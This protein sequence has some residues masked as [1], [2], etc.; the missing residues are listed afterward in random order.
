M[1]KHKTARRDFLKA[2]GVVAAPYF[3]PARVLGAEAP[4][5][6]LRVGCIGVGRQGSADMRECLNQGLDPKTAA[7]VVAVCDVDQRRATNAQREVASFYRQQRPG[8]TPSPIDAVSD[9]RELLSRSDIDALLIATP[10]HWHGPAASLAAKAGKSIYLQKPLAYTI[11]EGRQLVDAVRRAGVVLQTGSQQ[12]SDRHFRRAC[13]LVRN[14]RIGRLR[15]I[16]VTLPPDVGTAPMIAGVA[17]PNLDYD[18]WL[19]PAPLSDYSETRVH[20]QD[21][22]GRPGWLQIEPYCRGMI[23]GWG[24]HMLDIAQWGHDSDDT[25]PT[26]IEGKAEFPERGVFNVHTTFNASCRYTDGVVIEA[27]TGEPAGVVFEGDEGTVHTGRWFVKTQPESLL[28]SPLGPAAVRL[29]K[30][31]NHMADFLRCARE[32][33]D[34]ACPVEVGHR[35][36]T[37][38]VL[39]HI[40]MKLGRR[41]KWDPVA[42]RFSGDEEAN[43][44]LDYPHREP[45]TM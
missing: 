2:V 10:D 24:S 39:M 42:E 31:D 30:S 1:W 8:S 16:V 6:K 44:L 19:G 18:K 7:E 11:R 4:S 13:E 9:F 36:N 17:P 25:G 26:E 33:I 15:R 21:G 23:S 37:V 40:A 5:N 29:Y 27:A 34:P 22:Y 45:W 35:S 28:Q 14:G 3:V 38:C 12:R 41:L 32:G 20:P 43:A